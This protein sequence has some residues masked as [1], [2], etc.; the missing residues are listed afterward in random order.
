MN[1][2][3][4]PLMDLRLKSRHLQWRRHQ[5]AGRKHSRK[6]IEMIHKRGAVRFGLR[7]LK[8]P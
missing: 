6:H 1:Q 5:Q 8:M 4:P 3:L 2:N 7:G